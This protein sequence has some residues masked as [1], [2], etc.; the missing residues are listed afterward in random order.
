MGTVP[1]K[2]PFVETEHLMSNFDSFYQG[3]VSR[4]VVKDKHSVRKKYANCTGFGEGEKL[5]DLLMA[6]SGAVSSRLSG[7][8]KTTAL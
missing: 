8:V 6:G 5:D 4:Q 1:L 3:V 2:K 7:F